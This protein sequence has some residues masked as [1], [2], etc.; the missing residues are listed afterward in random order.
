MYERIRA[1]TYEIVEAALE[2]D[3]TSHVFDLFI[4]FMIFLNLTAFIL[5]SVQSLS[6]EY[7]VFFAAFEAFSVAIFSVEYFLRLWS[8]VTAEAYRGSIRGRLRYAVTPFAVVDLVV[9]LPFY[10][11]L[12]VPMSESLIRVLRVMRLLRVFRLGRYSESL[13]SIVHIIWD[14][15]EE[16]LITTVVGG[17][18]LVIA[19]TLVFLVE[20]PIQPKA[21]S[22]IPASMWWG[23]A[24]L[25]TV[26][27]GDVY[28]VT[29]LGKVMGGA[30]ALIG[31]GMFALPTAILGSSFVEEMQ[32]RRRRP[33]AF[34]CP[35]CGKEIERRG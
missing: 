27:Y 28:P 13:R 21:F 17:I 6:D 7:G 14:K 25:T 9:I 18:L 30:I 23:V 11:I 19:S 22:S 15:K 26:G 8:C 31:V 34:T 10:I 3:H 29:P 24:T 33:G 1:R 2:T 12:L 32:R 35:H 4:Q 5:E 16:L 20:N